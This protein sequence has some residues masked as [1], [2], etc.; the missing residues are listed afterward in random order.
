MDTG[1]LSLG[2]SVRGVILTTY[3]S[4]DVKNEW[5]YT[6]IPGVNRGNFTITFT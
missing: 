1:V 6:S 3:S 2:Y 5:L 4:A